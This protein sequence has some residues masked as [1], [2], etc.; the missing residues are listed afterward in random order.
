MLLVLA[1][2]PVSSALA[3]E[4]GLAPTAGVMGH[5]KSG[6]SV[7]VLSGL[8]ISIM[9]SGGRAT[10]GKAA[11]PVNVPN[12]TPPVKVLQLAEDT[13]TLLPHNPLRLV[14]H[15]GG[16]GV[17]V[18]PGST[19]VLTAACAQVTSYLAGGVVRSGR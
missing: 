9:Y 16:P 11:A 10:P 17:L 2:P 14:G 8:I 1:P 5:S 12:G 13:D 15:Q 19:V 7:E 6:S 4:L 18:E 3:S